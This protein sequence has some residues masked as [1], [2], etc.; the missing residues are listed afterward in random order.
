MELSMEQRRQAI[1]EL[2][3]AKGSVS[4]SQLKDAFPQ[5][6][7]MTLRTDLKALDAA[8][9]LVR[10]HG[11]AKS[12]EVVVGTD[13]L[14]GR[15]AVRNAEAKQRIAQKALSLIRPNSTLFLD[16]GSTTTA[17]ARIMPDEPMLIY[18]GGLNCALEL[19]RLAVP[20]VLLPGGALNRY[21]LSVCGVSSVQ[22]LS[23]VNFDLMLLGVT[24]YSREAGFT[25]GVPEEAALKRAVIERSEQVAVLLDSSKLGLKTSCTICGLSQVDVIL[26][27]GQL[28]PDFLEE[29][30]RLGITVY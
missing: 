18:T 24:A 13:D 3:N 17:V 1:V 16:S 7:D 15:R 14:F 6:S 9:R 10:I 28:P 22:E 27:D 19:A 23:R 29:C 20:R 25:C 4:F 26:S 30:D 8:R 2:V 11:G 12:V 5:V 21:S